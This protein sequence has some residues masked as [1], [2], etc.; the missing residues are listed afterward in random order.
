VT[1]ETNTTAG[2]TMTGSLQRLS[3]L[4]TTR[5]RFLLGAGGVA[6]VGLLAACGDDGDD[7]SSDGT[8]TTP[9]SGTTGMD[10]EPAGDA[11][12]DLEIGAFA[13]SL[14]VLAVNTYTAAAE[15]ATGGKLGEVPPAV[16]EFV[17]TALGHHQEALD[18]WNGVLTEA[19]EPEVT[20]PPADLKATVDEEFGKVTDVVGA[21]RLAL[22]LEQIAAATYLEAI[23]VLT[24]EGAIG[25]AASIQPID[26]QHAAVL[27]FVLGEY[28]VPDNFAKTDMS[29]VP[30]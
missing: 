15:A 23:P 27:L 30:K 22:M 19:G 5:R 7:T 25:L 11:S 4:A 9:K 1:D 24:T 3:E 8:T 26:M 14:E 17:T 16:V 6:A 29:A 2:D 21:A 10:D 13:A 12:G 28:P 18:A 20:E